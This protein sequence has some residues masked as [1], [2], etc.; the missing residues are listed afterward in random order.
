M[1]AEILAMGKT[2][3]ANDRAPF[4]GWQSIAHVKAFLLRE[5]GKADEVRAPPLRAF[6]EKVG[7]VRQ[8]GAR[9]GGGGRGAAAGR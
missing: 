9:R 2:L 5:L 4:P 7:V 3:F 1:C 6:L 8:Q